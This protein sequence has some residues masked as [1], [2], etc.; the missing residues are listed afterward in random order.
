MEE[1]RK[2]IRSM[3]VVAD[4]PRA[5]IDNILRT[6]T[7]IVGASIDDMEVKPLDEVH[8]DPGGMVY[9]GS[10]TIDFEVR[11]ISFSVYPNQVGGA[12]M[13][14]SHGSVDDNRYP[15]FTR[16][17]MGYFCYMLP[18]EF[19][20]EVKIKLVELERR[21]E[22]LHAELNMQKVLDHPGILRV[23]PDEALE[24]PADKRKNE[25]EG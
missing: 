24:L 21:D 4:D 17:N 8:L 13:A 7:S 15:G 19:W 23:E 2:H 12:I 9:I 11:G 10:G 5:E 20:K 3:I 1:D 25:K 6:S 22:V 16:G 14:M 18:S